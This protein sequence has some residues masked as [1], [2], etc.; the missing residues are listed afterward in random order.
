MISFGTH[1]VFI[2]LVIFII[3]YRFEKIKHRKRLK[4]IPLRIWVNGTRGKSSV[5]RLIAA[6]LRAG[7]KKV[8]AKTTG[9]SPRLI[10]NNTTE[11]PVSRLGMAN[12]SEQIKI[13]KK[14]QGYDPEAIVLECMALRPDLQRTEALKIIEPNVVVITNVRPDHLDVMGPTTND[15]AYAFI[16]AVPDH[17]LIFT[18]EAKIINK[19]I[20]MV[21][22]KDIRISNVSD[23]KIAS[24][25]LE[26]FSYIEHKENIALALA[27]CQHYGIEEK[28]ALQGMQQMTPDPGALKKYTLCFGIKKVTMVNAMAANDPQSTLLI[29]TAIDKN[30]ETINLLI[31]CRDDRIDRSF[32]I[33]ELIKNHMKADHIILSGKGTGVL[34]KQLQ[35]TMEGKK[36]LDLGNKNPLQVVNIVADIITD[37]SLIFT[38][39]NTVGFGTLLINEF[40]NYRSK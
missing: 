9:T 21:N 25:T 19:Y 15:I 38:L 18:S 3:L 28:T 8:I 30:Y 23:D 29:W 12:I 36:I 7:G 31:N 40:L 32:Q 17:C 5:T 26:E 33:A 1:A 22:K 13:I 14:V 37:N 34:R 11:Y 16:N 39:G 24:K 6:G 35:K 27:V 20:D 10:L 2:L 4:S